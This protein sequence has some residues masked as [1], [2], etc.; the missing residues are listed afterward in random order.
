SGMAPTPGAAN[1]GV[2]LPFFDDFENGA[3]A[4]WRPAFTAPLKVITPGT[5]EKPNIVPPAPAGGKVL[6]VYDP[7]GGGDVNYLPGAFD[8]LNFEGYIWIP[9]AQ[10]TDKPW[11]TG[12]GINTRVESSWFGDFSG[13]ALP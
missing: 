10:G 13:Y 4:A 12:V 11:S 6:E 3:E 9:Q 5:P 7:T 8:Q 1:V 2:T